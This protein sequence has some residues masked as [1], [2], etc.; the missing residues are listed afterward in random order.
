MLDRL[1]V[2]EENGQVRVWWQPEGQLRPEA[3]GEPEPFS[4]PL[5]PQ[6]LEEFRWYL[7]D[8]LRAPYAVYENRG[9]EIEARLPELGERLFQSLFGQG[10][11]GRD[12]YLKGRESSSWEL[13]FASSSP[14]FLSLPWELLRDPKRGTPLALD[15]AGAH[16]TIESPD[17]PF[18]ARSGETLKV[19]MVIARPYGLRDVPYRT[20]ARPLL[21]RLKPVAGKADVDVLGVLSSQDTVPERFRGKET[22]DWRE[23]AE[24]CVEIGLLTALG[25]GMFRIHPALPQYL[26]AL[27]RQQASEQY[28]TE[29]A[30]ALLASIRAHAVLGEWL[31]NQIQGGEAATAFA[32]LDLERRSFGAAAG[33]ALDQ[34]LYAEAQAI[35]QPL[36]ELWKVR[37]LHAEAR[38]WVDRC[39]EALEGT[40]GRAPDLETPAGA[41]WLFMVGSEAN[42]A[43]RAGRLDEAEAEHDRVRRALEG[44]RDERSRSMLAVAYHQLGMVAQDRGD[45]SWAERWYS[46]SLEIEGSLGNRP[47]MARSY[48]QLGMV[49]QLRGDLSSAGRWYRQSLEILESL[50]DRPE[51][52]RSYHQLG[53]VAQDRGDLS[54]AERWYRQSLEIVES[55]GDRPGMALSYGQLGLLAEARVCRSTVLIRAPSRSRGR[56]CRSRRA[57]RRRRLHGGR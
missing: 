50:G 39:R 22:E 26:T 31:W 37:G 15:L 51:M 47:G 19:L 13:W 34:G 38:S 14:E 23:L 36:N 40:A 18:E 55:L 43:H 33:A 12:A 11:A 27:W 2:E 16:R 17:K 49:A 29:E 46:H 32:V 20:V 53:V 21:E 9:R 24:R 41:L 6:E 7:E 42:R 8:Y 54:S 30:D 3:P 57:L 4:T 56:S 44:K 25:A 35:L 5:T 45:L 10:K 1:F 28:E 52:A 48:H